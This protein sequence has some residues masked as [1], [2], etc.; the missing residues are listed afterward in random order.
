M[1]S[2]LCTL[3]KASEDLLDDIVINE[4]RY[5]LEDMDPTA[6][7]WGVY[8]QASGMT[9]QVD[10]FLKAAFEWAPERQGQAWL[11]RII[12]ATDGDRRQLTRIAKL[13]F[14]EVLVPSSSIEVFVGQNTL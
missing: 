8:G 6:F 4:A 13:F 12:T 11:G 3:P 5:I 10:A 2:Q 7:H 9:I 1:K 14:E